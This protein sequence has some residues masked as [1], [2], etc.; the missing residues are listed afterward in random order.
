MLAL[1]ITSR[2]DYEIREIR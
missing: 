2:L 1:I